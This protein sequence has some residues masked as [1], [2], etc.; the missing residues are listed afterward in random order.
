MQRCTSPRT[1]IGTIVLTLA[2]AGAEALTVAPAM[3]QQDAPPRS[4]GRQAQQD[5]PRGQ[6]GQ[7]G[8]G[9]FGRLL[10]RGMGGMGNIAGPG[11]QNQFRSAME[12]DFVRRDIPLFKTQLGLEAAELMV[13]EQLLHDYE[14]AFLPARQ[15]MQD[16]MRDM[17]RQLMAPMM[18]AGVQERMQ[19][20]M[21]RAR[22]QMEQLEAE[23]GAEL[24]PEERQEFFRDQMMRAGEEIHKEMKASGMFSELRAALKP[25]VQDFNQ[26]QATKARLRDAL[27][28]GVQASLSDQQKARWPAFERFLTREKTIPLGTLSGEQVNLF[29]VLDEAG[30]SRDTFQSLTPILDQYELELHEALRARNEYYKAN[31]AKFLEAIVAGDAS[32]ASRLM[33]RGMALRERVRDVNDRFRE[34]IMAQLPP[35]DAGRV[36]KEALMAAYERVYQPTPVELAF[37]AIDEM[38]GLDPAVLES[39][40]AL[41]AQY[42]TELGVANDRLVQAIRKQ[43]PAQQVEDVSRIVSLLSGD[44][45]FASMMRPRRDDGDVE[46]LFARRRTTDET[47]MERLRNLLSAEQFESLPRGGP[48]NR[49]GRAGGGPG[50]GPFGGDGGPMRLAD[51]PED[52]RNRVARFD[53]NN[54]GVLDESERTAMMEEFRSQGRAGRAF[55][56]NGAPGAPGGPGGG[57][58]GGRGGQ[59]GGGRGGQGGAA[60]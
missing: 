21:Q 1:F 28:S 45:S 9:G 5:G 53:A 12:P 38:E 23:K 60:D 32:E 30:L 29:L 15:E 2:V 14:D 20:S 13:L 44:V 24:T 40:H 26:W 42:Q 34:A 55:G 33:Q 52:F 7:R 27:V 11:L 3:A 16:K 54:D 35:A 48:G 58:R 6:D 51:L 8:R 17:G 59:G 18:D 50:G 56:G 4:G 57:G 47:Y 19:Q 39:V 10:G 36:R 43:E 49:G 41:D 22:E 37:R 31:E 25:M 46:D